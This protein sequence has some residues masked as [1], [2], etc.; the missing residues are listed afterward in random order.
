MGKNLFYRK[1]LTDLDNDLIIACGEYEGMGEG[2]V[3]DLGMDM[4]T[5]LCL[6]QIINKELLFLVQHTKLCLMLCGSLDGSEVW[7]RTDR[8][9]CMA[10]SLPCSPET[11]YI[12]NRLYPNA[13]EVLK[14]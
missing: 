11:H 5:L 7:G 9:I 4:Y 10:E 8:C 13:K 1:R 12:V 14:N 3:R 6:K 2:I